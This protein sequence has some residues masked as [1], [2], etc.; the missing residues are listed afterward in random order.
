[1]AVAKIDEQVEGNA[2]ENQVVD[3]PYGEMN[4]WETCASSKV[5]PESVEHHAF[6]V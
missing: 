1:V 3:V 5:V 4:E 6:H 2:K